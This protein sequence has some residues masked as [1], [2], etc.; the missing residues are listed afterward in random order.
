M[1]K[2]EK[3]KLFEELIEKKAVLLSPWGSHWTPQ[4]QYADG[5]V[6]VIFTNTTHGGETSEFLHWIGV[7]ELSIKDDEI[8]MHGSDGWDNDDSLHGQFYI[9]FN[10]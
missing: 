5:E 9:P 2:S 4:L 10:L 3:I 6:C 8:Y 7:D 1:T